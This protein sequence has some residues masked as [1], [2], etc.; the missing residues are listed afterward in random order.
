MIQENINL[1]K[2]LSTIIRDHPMCASFN[3]FDGRFVVYYSDGMCLDG[4]RAAYA[5]CG[6]VV[7]L[8]RILKAMENHWFESVAH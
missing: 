1:I 8:Q 4:V 7:A 6:K 5:N 2:N 3:D